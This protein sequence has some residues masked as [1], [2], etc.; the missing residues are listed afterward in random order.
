MG[1]VW[2]EVCVLASGCWCLQVG[3]TT[4]C[5]GDWFCLL[6]VSLQ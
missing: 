6:Q 2:V 3:L 4:K 5:E 1:G